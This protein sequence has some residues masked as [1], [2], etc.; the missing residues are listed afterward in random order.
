MSSAVLP[1]ASRSLLGS[2]SGLC[3]VDAND[4]RTFKGLNS[5][6][7]QHLIDCPQLAELVSLNAHLY[8]AEF[9]GEPGLVKGCSGYG[10]GMT[11]F[12]E[13]LKHMTVVCASRVSGNK[14]KFNYGGCEFKES[15][16]DVWQFCVK[17][18]LIDV[19][20][21]VRKSAV[22]NYPLEILRDETKCPCCMD[23]LSGNVVACANKHQ[24]CLPCFNLLP[25]SGG[26][27]KC[28]LCNTPTYTI[29]ELA[30]VRKMNGEE[31]RDDPYFY[32]DINS[33]RNS[34]Q[35]F[36]YNEAY[37]LHAIKWEAKLDNQDKFA[38]MLLSS[39]YNFYITHKEAFGTYT[40]NALNQ[41]NG[42]DRYLKPTKEDLPLAFDFYFLAL[43][44]PIEYKK[45]YDDVAHTAIYLHNYHDADFY[46]QLEDLEGDMNRLKDYP[47]SRKDILKR[48]VYFR[49]KIKSLQQYQ[50]KQV[51]VNILQRILK[52]SGRFSTIYNQIKKIEV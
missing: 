51:V 19:I 16:E 46:N 1:V 27:R 41:I 44:E 43:T 42:N 29:D 2:R 22:V 11:V 35:D 49:Y 18:N 13:N 52:E 17:K 23:D 12:S 8:I 26:V 45:I 30:K 40:F 28:P 3:V 39:F 34:F 7:R 24:V 31:V 6:T 14:I 4:G 32:I 48:E 50:L 25:V 15:R 37:F 10:F 38:T 9:G 36:C 33:G 21:V 5:F 47:D 20:T